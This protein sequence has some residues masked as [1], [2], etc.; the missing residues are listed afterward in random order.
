MAISISSKGKNL[1]DDLEHN[2]AQFGTYIGTMHDNRTSA[3]KD[4]IR[5]C[6]AALD[7]DGNNTHNTTFTI[8]ASLTNNSISITI[9]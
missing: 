2:G 5:A 8:A 9:S 3:F 6:I 4:A 1:R 7:V